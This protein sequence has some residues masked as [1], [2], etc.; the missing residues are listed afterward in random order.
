MWVTENESLNT[1]GSIRTVYKRLS[2]KIKS[3]KTIHFT[4]TIKQP[5]TIYMYFRPELFQRCECLHL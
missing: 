3:N 2:R 1:E 5:P 4:Q